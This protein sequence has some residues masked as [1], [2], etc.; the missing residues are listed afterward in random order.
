MRPETSYIESSMCFMQCA[1]VHAQ[2]D[3]GNVR[4]TPAQPLCTVDVISVFLH[5]AW[6]F[7]FGNNKNHFTSLR[8]RCADKN[9]A[10]ARARTRQ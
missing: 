1:A 2:Q 9:R 6:R 5:F 8:T 3:D 7:L 4:S 10:L